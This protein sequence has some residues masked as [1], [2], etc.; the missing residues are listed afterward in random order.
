[1]RSVM[2]SH[3]AGNPTQYAGVINAEKCI[4]YL[5]GIGVELDDATGDS[6][7]DAQAVH[8]FLRRMKRPVLTF[9][10]HFCRCGEM[11]GLSVVGEKARRWV[12]R[13]QL[14][15]RDEPPAK[16]ESCGTG[17]CG[18]C[19]WYEIARDGTERDYRE[20]AVERTVPFNWREFIGGKDA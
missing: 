14:E 3:I 2:A 6:W 9:R 20:P 4:K 17:F 15:A 13:R 16:C 18:W 7:L 10:R 11:E 5:R 1:M 12:K 19:R 8:R